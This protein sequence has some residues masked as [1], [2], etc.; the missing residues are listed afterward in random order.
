L[1]S[2]LLVREDSPRYVLHG[3]RGSFVKYGIDVQE[4]HLKAGLTPGAP[5]FGIE[6]EAQWGMLNTEWNGLHIR[7]RVE[8]LPGNWMPLFQNLYEAIRQGAAPTID[9]QDIVAQL[10]VFEA[11]DAEIKHA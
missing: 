5:G 7:G 11:I 4:D 3:T 6:P 10:R 9:L 1:R 8:T 2:S